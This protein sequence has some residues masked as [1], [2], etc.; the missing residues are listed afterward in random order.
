MAQSQRV[1]M[2]FDIG[3]SGLTE[4]IHIIGDVITGLG[5]TMWC[6]GRLTPTTWSVSPRPWNW[7]PEAPTFATNPDA[8]GPTERGP[9][10]ACGAIAALIEKA[11]GRSPL[12]VGKPNQLMIRTAFNYLGVHSTNTMTV[13][14]RMD[15]DIIAGGEGGLE[16][17]LVLSGVARPEHIAG[18]P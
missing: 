11:S 3:E 16:T 15:T 12:F 13:G 18:F 5:P 4:V 10:P 1:G 14:D 2:A 8:V 9:V 6:W 7:W 17:S